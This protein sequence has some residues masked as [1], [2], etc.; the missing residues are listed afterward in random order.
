MAAKAATRSLVQMHVCA[1]MAACIASGALDARLLPLPE[2]LLREPVLLLPRFRLGQGR[3]AVPQHE[4]KTRN[5]F[6]EPILLT[7]AAMRLF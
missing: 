6:F 2:R 5:A 3:P 1:E 7:P 4:I